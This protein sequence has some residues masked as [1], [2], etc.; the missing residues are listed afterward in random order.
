MHGAR[1]LSFIGEEIPFLQDL[2]PVATFLIVTK[3]SEWI[4]LGKN[5]NR[6]MRYTGNKSGG[7]AHY[8]RAFLLIGIPKL[9]L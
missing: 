4:T 1:D 2:P 7:R 5:E 9:T 8:W 6:M 3:L